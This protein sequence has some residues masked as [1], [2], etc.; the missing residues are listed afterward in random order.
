ARMRILV[1][2]AY[3]LIGTEVMHT[4][5]AA[6]LQVVG[7]GRSVVLGARLLPHAQ[8][9]EGDMAKMLS[10][11]DWLPVVEGFDAVVNCAGALQDGSRDQLLAV[12]QQ[13][14]AGLVS[15]CE[16]G[17]VQQ[18]VQISVPGVEL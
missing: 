1:L 13:A 8:W 7:F 17:G 11:R 2:G 5:L 18:F 10:A 15:A 4:L 16:E 9:V 6:G 12:H 3:G 14:I